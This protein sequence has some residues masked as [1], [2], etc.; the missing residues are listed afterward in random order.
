MPL[1]AIPT[2]RSVA[3]AA[4]ARTVSAN[5]NE[6]LLP[7]LEDWI[8]LRHPLLGIRANQT[9][10]VKV[11]SIGALAPHCSQRWLLEETEPKTR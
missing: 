1:M 5:L 9:M 8:V 11:I 6:L 2:I 10:S 4:F 7:V 3:I